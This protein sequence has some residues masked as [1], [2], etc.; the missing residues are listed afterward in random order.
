[1]S[2]TGNT[3][4]A[5]ERVHPPRW[6]MPLV[7]PI[8]RFLI[9]KG[10][11]AERLLL[12]EFDGRRTGR[13]YEIPVGY[14]YLEGRRLVLTDSGWRHNFSDGADIYITCG[15]TRQRVHARLDPNPKTVAEVYD[16]LIGELG[17]QRAGRQLGIRINADRRPTPGELE[18]LAVRTGLSIIWLD[19]T[20]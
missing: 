16:R 20:I 17:W 3:K 9:R 1:M 18:D 13:Q 10:R 11:L 2:T 8:M 12:L 6:L 7:N 5:G 4:P 14:R 15:G 19:D